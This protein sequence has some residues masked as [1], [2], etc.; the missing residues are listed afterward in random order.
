[1]RAAAFATIVSHFACGRVGYTLEPRLEQDAAIPSAD[2]SAVDADIA[3]ARPALVIE[4]SLTADNAYGFGYGNGSQ[5]A[6]YSP[7]VIN[8]LASDIFN[9][10]EGGVERYLMPAEARTTD[11]HL[12][13]IAWADTTGTQG[14]LGEFSE[15]GGETFYTGTDN[16]EVCG[17]DQNYTPESG[18]PTIEV[19]N[20]EIQSCNAA[21]RW[22]D[23][24]GDNNQRLEIGEDN[25][26]NRISISPGN[27]FPLTCHS[28]ISPDA[29]WMW[30][31][32]DVALIEQPS[33][34]AFIWPSGTSEN[35]DHQF[36]IF[37][38]ALL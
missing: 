30:L 29:R 22:L 19:I 34:S 25:S 27:E 23:S 12:Y 33:E 15:I 28:E 16:W 38:R 4:A 20:Q 2:A 6:H 3:D 8:I 17:T 13:I 1:M 26:T 37:R 11:A 10:D 21:S 35:V 32:W 18:G 36:L 9:C 5:L 31:N 7:P 14:V 24:V